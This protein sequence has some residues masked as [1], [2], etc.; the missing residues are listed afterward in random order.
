ME[1]NQ[2]EK[3]HDELQKYL[4]STDD[5]KKNLI[6]LLERGHH[7]IISHC[8]VFDLDNV[9]GRN[10]VFNWVR[11]EFNGYSEHFFDSFLTELNTFRMELWM[12]GGLDVEKT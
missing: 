11:F 1:T 7:V 10:L 3:H 5:D 2:Y 9:V 4:K 12:A 6:S 8:G